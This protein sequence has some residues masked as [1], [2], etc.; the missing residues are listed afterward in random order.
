VPDQLPEAVQ[1]VAFLAAQESVELEPLVTL[2]GAADSD[3]VGAA[4][5][6]ETVTDCVALPPTPLHVMVYVL[7]LVIA[8]VV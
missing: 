1:A 2:L 8:P 6:T 4:E 3:T 7:L 5:L